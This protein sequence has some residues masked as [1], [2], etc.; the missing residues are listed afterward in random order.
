VSPLLIVVIA[1]GVI[2]AACWIASLITKDTS[3]VDRIWSL[4]PIVYVWIFSGAAGLADTRLDIMAILVTVWGARLTYNFARKGGYSGVEDYRW[5]VL[6]ARMPAAAWPWFNLG[7]I[8][9]VQN[10]V[11]LGMTLPAWTAYE[12]ATDLGATFGW[13]VY[14]P[15]SGA[16]FDPALLPLGRSLLDIVLILAFVACL[17]GETIAD[18]QQWDFHRAKHAGGPDF[19]PRFCQTGLFRVSRHPNYF[20][21]LAQWWLF[22]GL[23]AAAV[24]TPLIWTGAGVLLL[25]AVFVGSTIFTES[26]TRGKYPE[27]AEYQARVSPIVPWF[28]RRRPAAAS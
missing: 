1:A 27:Y 10:A 28:P 9:I 16:T 4:A 13:T 12:A 8:V 17:A 2:A 19:R 6:R 14:V 22:F 18:R 20:F 7:F 15:I 26:I 21:E 24:G 25:T 3:W 11:I 5:A 23:G